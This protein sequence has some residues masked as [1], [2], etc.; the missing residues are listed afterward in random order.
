MKNKEELIYQ[1]KWCKIV[2]VGTYYV[3][4][5][6]SDKYN[7][8]YFFTLDECYKKTGLPPLP[9]FSDMSDTKRHS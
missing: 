5:S 9:K 6:K 8:Q 4:R 2:L 3:L 1:N 7:D